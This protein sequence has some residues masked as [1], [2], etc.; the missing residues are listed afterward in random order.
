MFKYTLA[1][2]SGQLW[3]HKAPNKT[4]SQLYYVLINKKCKNS[5]KKAEHIIRLLAYYWTTAL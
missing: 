3:T 1:E 2:K 4:S 5:T